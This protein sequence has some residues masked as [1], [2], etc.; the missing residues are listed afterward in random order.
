MK[1]RLNAKQEEILA[2]F[3][4]QRVK[5]GKEWQ[6]CHNQ[7]VIMEFASRFAEAGK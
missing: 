6:P 5:A 2:A 4:E 3:Q 7:K 1:A